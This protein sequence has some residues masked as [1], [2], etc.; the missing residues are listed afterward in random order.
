M[1]KENPELQ[2]M[3]AT[4]NEISVRKTHHLRYVH[5]FPSLQ[6]QLA[7]NINTLRPT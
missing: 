5:Q 3:G 1:S 2:V 4:V 6:V 7:S